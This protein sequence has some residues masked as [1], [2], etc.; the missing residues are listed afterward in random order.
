MEFIKCFCNDLSV[1]E[2]SKKL[3]STHIT[4]RNKYKIFRELIALHLEE[5]FNKNRDN[6]KEYNEYIYLDKCKRGKKEYIFD[7][8]NFLT[9]DYGNKVYSIMMSLLSRY[10]SILI[11]EKQIDL[12]YKELSKFLL[13]NKVAKLEKLDN[14]IQKFWQFLDEVISK[15]RGI[16]EKN[17]FYYLKEAE[18]KFNYNKDEKFE[19]LRSLYTTKLLKK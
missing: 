4:A 1:K 17:F 9:F 5:E 19:I 10:K 12:Y 8:Q 6:I 7:G 15:Y 3:N 18:F 13:F 2:A 14:N 11:D 16:N